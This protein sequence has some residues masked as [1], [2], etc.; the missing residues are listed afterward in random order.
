MEYVKE[1]LD[2]GQTERERREREREGGGGRQ[3]REEKEGCWVKVT[4]RHGRQPT[5]HLYLTI[6]LSGPLSS[7]LPFTYPCL[8]CR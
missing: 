1:A 2:G 8:F 4:E 6:N 3:V 5:P 7:P